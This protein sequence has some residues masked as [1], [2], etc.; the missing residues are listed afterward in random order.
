MTRPDET[1][2]TAPVKVSVIV[3]AFNEEASLPACLE[4]LG[5]QTY[6]DL[7]V[8]VV[9]DGSTD[10]TREVARSHRARVLEQTHRGPG[11][12]R[13]LGARGASGR[14]LV[15]IDADMSFDPAFV[16]KLT[17]P[18][19]R[20]SA[21]GTFTIE[22]YVANP[23]H[24]WARC[25]SLNLRL[26]PDRRIPADH[27]PESD[28]F[29]AVDRD[30]FL[31]AGGFSEGAGYS[32]DRTLAAKI[33]CRAVAAPGAVCYHE[34]PTRLGEVYRQARWIGRSSLYAG[35]PWY[36]VVYSPPVSLLRGIATGLRRREPLFPIFKLVYDLG[37]LLGMLSRMLGLDG[38]LHAK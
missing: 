28:V 23:E 19:R 8:I 18:I 35:K 20:G 29:R 12:A 38:G 14:I 30:R 17:E 31:A 1:T 25:W 5:R 11:A 33:G 16:D 21:V 32:D 10:G 7:E 26:P 4:T 9:D 13:N 36:L 34:N 15:L 24:H 22:E 6:P 37:I 27:P 2:G 3:P